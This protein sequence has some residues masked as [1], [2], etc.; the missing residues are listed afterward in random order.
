MA[1]L[2]PFRFLALALLL[3]A[4]VARAGAQAP[5]G[6]ADPHSLRKVDSATSATLAALPSLD[7]DDAIRWSELKK[8]RLSRR[9]PP[10]FPE[11]IA[12]LDGRRVR[13]VGFMAPFDSL[14]DMRNFMLLPTLVGC[15]FCVPPSALE[16]VLVRVKADG[17]VPFSEPAIEVTGTLKLW[18]AESGDA[19]HQ[20]FLFIMD[21]AQFKER[22]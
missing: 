7:G 9:P 10:V 4:F 21:D 2:H 6:G 18:K 15:Y 8:T 22:K 5:G 20:Y 11:R 12:A 17:P 19:G 14:T 16:V 3:P 13:M 1:L